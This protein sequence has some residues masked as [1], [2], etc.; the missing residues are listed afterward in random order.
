[1]MATVRTGD[2]RAALAALLLRRKDR[3]SL[4]PYFPNLRLLELDHDRAARR[5]EA[6]GYAGAHLP[7]LAAGLT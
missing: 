1:M 5:L 6:A 4:D 3:G 2:G 7:R